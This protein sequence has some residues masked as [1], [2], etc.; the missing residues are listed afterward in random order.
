MEE[1]NGLTLRSKLLGL[2]IVLL[3]GM[4]LFFLAF[5]QNP[6]YFKRA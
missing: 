6:Q 1:G 2:Q 4:L 3:I 5:E